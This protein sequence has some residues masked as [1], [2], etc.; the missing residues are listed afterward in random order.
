MKST[1]LKSLDFESNKRSSCNACT[2]ELRPTHEMEIIQSHYEQN[3]ADN[4]R[5]SR[6]EGQS[7]CSSEDITSFLLKNTK[8]QLE[9]PTIKTLHSRHEPPLRTGLVAWRLVV[10]IALVALLDPTHGVHAHTLNPTTESNR[11]NQSNQRLLSSAVTADGTILCDFY[12]AVPSGN[13]GLL[14]NWC[15]Y[16]LGRL[17]RSPLFLVRNHVRDFE[18]SQPSD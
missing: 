18:R 11:T 7:P 1:Y 5:N 16:R 10:F 4:S 13:R 9:F 3:S 2:E 14:S 6:Y 8:T 12:N 15:G 17:R